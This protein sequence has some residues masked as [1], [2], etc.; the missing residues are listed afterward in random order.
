[1]SSPQ[2]EDGVIVKEQQTNQHNEEPLNNVHIGDKSSHGSIPRSQNDD[3]N[4]NSDKN[5]NTGNEN[6]EGPVIEVVENIEE[7]AVTKGEEKNINNNTEYEKTILPPVSNSSNPAVDDVPATV[8]ISPLVNSTKVEKP[9]VSKLEQMKV[10]REKK[11]AEAKAKRE[12]E[13]LEREKA[14]KSKKRLVKRGMKSDE[15]QSMAVKKI[16]EIRS[17]VSEEILFKRFCGYVYTTSR[18][19]G[20]PYNL[21]KWHRRYMELHYK[22]IRFLKKKNGTKNVPRRF[23][24][25]K[26]T[27]VKLMPA[28]SEEHSYCFEIL[29]GGTSKRHY[30]ALPTYDIFENWLYALREFIP[31]VM[32]H[33]RSL[34]VKVLGSNDEALQDYTPKELKILQLKIAR[35]FRLVKPKH[36]GEI[37]KDELLHSIQTNETLQQ[38]LTSDPVLSL[39]LDSSRYS[40]DFMTMDANGDGTINYEELLHF[41]GILRSRNLDRKNITNKFFRLIDKNNNGEL[42]KDELMR[43]IMR[44]KEVVLHLKNN[45]ALRGLLHPKTYKKTFDAMDTNND[46][47]I[48]LE[49]MRAFLDRH[50]DGQ[51]RRRMAITKVFELIDTNN[52]GTLQCT[53]IVEAIAKIPALTVL[54]ENEKSLKPLLQQSGD[55]LAILKEM[56]KDDD[57]TISLEELLMWCSVED[58][59]LQ[60]EMW[61]SIRVF[62]HLTSQKPLLVDN[63]LISLA[64]QGAPGYYIDGKSLLKNVVLNPSK[65]RNELIKS[66]KKLSG[67]LTPS[68]YSSTVLAMLGTWHSGRMN[69]EA[70]NAFCHD[71]IV[72]QTFASED[73]DRSAVHHTHHVKGEAVGKGDFRVIRDVLFSAHGDNTRKEEQK[74]QRNIKEENR[75]RLQQAREEREIRENAKKKELQEKDDMDKQ[76]EEKRV[77]MEKADAERK[78]N[79]HL[80]ATLH[81]AHDHMLVVVNGSKPY[82]VGCRRIKWDYDFEKARLDERDRNKET[83]DWVDMAK[84]MEKAEEGQWKLKEEDIQRR[85]NREKLKFEHGIEKLKRRFQLRKKISIKGKSEAEVAEAIR[86]SEPKVYLG[87]G[88]GKQKKKD[89][90]KDID[91]S[92][93]AYNEAANELS[94]ESNKKKIWERAEII[95]DKKIVNR[96]KE[97]KT[98]WKRTIVKGRQTRFN[99]ERIRHLSVRRNIEAREEDNERISINY[100]EH[101]N[102]EKLEE[103]TRRPPEDLELRR[104]GE[105]RAIYLDIVSRLRTRGRMSRL[106][107]QRTLA[108]DGSTS[109]HDVLDTSRNKRYVVKVVS[110]SSENEVATM[111]D[112]VFL[113]RRVASECLSCVNIDDCFYHAITGFGGGYFM[114]VIIYECGTGGEL[115]HQVLEQAAW[116]KIIPPHP[117]DSLKTEREIKDWIKKHD[118]TGPPPIT[119]D[120]VLMWTL[121]IAKGLKKL[122]ENQFIHRNLKPSNVFLTE[123]LNAMI[124]DYPITKTYEGTLPIAATYTG[125][126]TYLAPELLNETLMFPGI[127]GPPI[128]VWSLGC[129]IYYL[130]SGLEICLTAEGN[131]PKPMDKLLDAVPVRFERTVRELIR[132][133]LVWDVDERATLDEIIQVV[134]EE[135]FERQ[136]AKQAEI[137]HRQSIV[138]LFERIDKDQSG[139]IDMDEL[140]VA[141]RSDKWVKRLLGRNDRLQP[142]LQPGK[143]RAM[144][145][146]IDKNGDGVVTLDELLDFCHVMDFATRH[147]RDVL[148]G[149]VKMFNIVDRDHSLTV[150]KTELLDALNTRPDV[151]EIVGNI[152]KLRPLLNTKTFKETFMKMDTNNGGSVTLDEMIEFSGIVRSQAEKRAAIK[153]QRKA[154]RRIAKKLAQ[155][156]R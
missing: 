14:K 136:E 143:A 47:V 141:I 8:N 31:S 69:F 99:D 135:Q 4:G 148:N 10:D 41:C 81:R 38:L 107:W 122:H 32:S 20:E 124:G 123:S 61:Y 46:G 130:C 51:R 112:D 53:E 37:Y 6:Q 5:I 150:E 35:I 93:D 155:Q 114:V 60:A 68:T 59:K 156:Y 54:I 82:C 91:D 17:G 15:M 98:H 12:K 131:L 87:K 92:L 94:L 63:S 44:N 86:Q 67:L 36:T 2:A 111:M 75:K 139:S 62:V 79:K 108:N 30:I 16:E 117:P 142:L 55:L 29:I 23:L 27:K 100:T 152:D 153:A 39:L 72:A 88:R 43:G 7:E 48:D 45:G 90:S 11:K 28:K 95:F 121:Q 105:H 80:H 13:K 22:E 84:K 66:L 71:K 110:C 151:R 40:Y 137:R 145:D 125:G 50:Y 127:I 24:I 115:E 104:Q 146:Q 97:F 33:L 154:E 49:E 78:K 65:A 103:Q 101:A 9:K 56:D 58:D 138:D 144:F 109:T 134:E 89:E 147:D 3:D 102:K 140:F 57:G 118:D 25:G 19:G 149:L 76:K 129:T 126:P 26:G 106:L 74:F 77:A 64:A 128:D 52:D 96:E 116:D 21:E 119:D 73:M 42:T 1:M 18:K 113:Q 70:F 120:K 132:M 83:K 133:T 85:E 34:R